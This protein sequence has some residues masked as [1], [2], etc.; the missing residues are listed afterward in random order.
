MIGHVFIPSIS[1]L[2]YSVLPA[3]R[4]CYLMLQGNPLI[5]AACLHQ[6][7]QTKYAGLSATMLSPFVP[8]F[9]HVV[10]QVHSAFVLL[11]LL[12]VL[13]GLPARSRLIYVPLNPQEYRA[14]TYLIIT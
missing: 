5:A 6:L 14:G 13:P 3:K 12:R 4:L 10:G 2:S 11:Q 9:D 1:P 8:M 7:K